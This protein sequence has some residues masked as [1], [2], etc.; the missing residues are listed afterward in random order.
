MSN[1]A[2]HSLT[3]SEAQG[4]LWILLVNFYPN[5]RHLDNTGLIS[6]VCVSW[7]KRHHVRDLAR[8]NSNVFALFD[9]KQISELKEAF[10]F[11][12]QNGDG[13]IDR[14]DLQEV[15]QSLGKQEINH[16]RPH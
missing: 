2:I 14:D 3:D 12:D 6:F 16:C 11:I 5:S 7:M 13:V 9:Q 10:S 15:F 4:Y 8:K 1:R